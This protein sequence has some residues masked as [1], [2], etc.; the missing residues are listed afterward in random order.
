MNFGNQI[1][2]LGRAD[3]VYSAYLLS[4]RIQFMSQLT[5]ILTAAIQLCDLDQQERPFVD[6]PKI[7]KEL[8][9]LLV[10]VEERDKS[11]AKA[12]E[13][14]ARLK[15]AQ[16]LEFAEEELVHEGVADE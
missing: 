16:E 2:G 8:K 14:L 9:A 6:N 5:E 7:A 11:I 10:R 1:Q 13:K 4:H 12:D 3:N 15:G